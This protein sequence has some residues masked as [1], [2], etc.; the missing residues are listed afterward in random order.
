LNTI[1]GFGKER[2]T[3]EIGEIGEAE[4]EEEGGR[5]TFFLKV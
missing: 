5:G 1:R 4:D 3:G 2:E